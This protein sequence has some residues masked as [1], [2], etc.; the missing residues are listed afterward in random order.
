MGHRKN[1]AGQK[2]PHDPVYIAQGTGPWRILQVA[3]KRFCHGKTGQQC[4]GQLTTQRVFEITGNAV[5]MVSFAQPGEQMVYFDVKVK[6]TAG[7]GKVKVLASS[8]Q[9]KATDITEIDVRNPNPVISRSQSITLAPGQSWNATANPLGIPSQSQAM[10]EISSIPPMN[11]QKRLQYLITYPHGCIEQ[12]TSS[13]FPQLVLKQLTDLN[14]QQK[15]EI[16]RN[17]KASIPASPIS[18][19]ETADLVTGLAQGESDDWGTNYAGHFLLEAQGQGYFV[20]DQ[21]MQQWK[22]YQRNKANNWIP[23][24]T[25]FYGGDLT[26]HTGYLRWHWRKLLNWEP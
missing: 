13:V 20:S 15:A 6:N 23:K 22:N 14:D 3:G 7:V 12:T 11:L 19:A 21:L 24:T 16:D 1:N 5:Q 4:A 8:G 9:E 17:I 10:L 18:R 26:R 2:A 25:N